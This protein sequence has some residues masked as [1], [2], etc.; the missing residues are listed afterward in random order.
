MHPST[1]AAINND[2]VTAVLAQYDSIPWTPQPGKHTVLAS[3]ALH[4]LHSGRTQLLS[5]GAGAKCL[6][7]DRLPVRG[8]SLHDSHAEV[9]ARR[10]A[11]R[12]LLEEA[13]RAAAHRHQDA[14]DSSSSASAS[15]SA[16]VWLSA[17]GR[18]VFALRDGV[19][20]DASMGLLASAQDP[21]VAC[22]M[23]CSD[24][25][26]RWSVLGIQGALASLVL[27]PVY[28]H[29]IVLG[30]VRKDCERAFR[31]RLGR[32]DGTLVHFTDVPFKHSRSMVS[33]T[34]T[35]SNDALCWVANCGWEVLIN[36]QKRGVPP[37]HKL[38]RKFRPML[39]KIALFELSRTTLH[40]STSYHATKQTAN[41][42][43]AAKRSLISPGAPFAG[44]VVSG[45]EWESFDT[46]GEWL[47]IA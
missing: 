16:S 7:A 25:I 8:D 45:E 35:T 17:T 39:S 43:Q 34:S 42:Y 23:S 19:R 26:A 6:P 36:G 33:V 14:R 18:L 29:A 22:S 40:E 10:G 11:V 9:I 47:G 46:H 5:L 20:G 4:D 3:F 28:I 38:N 27:Q 30:E 21:K 1:D 44:W 41:T 24:K 31:E 32:L 12:W 15:A 13:Q 37:K 2:V